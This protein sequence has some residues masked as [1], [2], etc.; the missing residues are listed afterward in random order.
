MPQKR[1]F[2]KH[3]GSRK[4]LGQYGSFYLV[5]A[6]NNWGSGHGY[7]AIRGDGKSIMAFI[8]VDKGK[9]TS[10]SQTDFF[11]EGDEGSRVYSLLRKEFP[12]AVQL[13]EDRKV[14]LEIPG[15]RPEE[16]ARMLSHIYDKFGISV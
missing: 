15:S 11:R 14:R 6:P 5:H 2:A 4:V 16:M 10:S 8:D 7:W 1:K 13:G 12:D 3:I 9:T